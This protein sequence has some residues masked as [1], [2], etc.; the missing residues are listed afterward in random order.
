[1]N[2]TPLQE[3]AKAFNLASKP[4]TTIAN[5]ISGGAKAI[6]N[7]FNSNKVS[8][9]NNNTSKNFDRGGSDGKNLYPW[10]KKTKV[11]R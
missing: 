3:V 1:M 7:L 11:A 5:F 6:G 2:K 4:F 10:L 8:T 9:I